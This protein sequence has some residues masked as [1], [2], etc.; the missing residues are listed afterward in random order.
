VR[1]RFQTR[2][3]RPICCGMD[4]FEAAKTHADAEA[5]APVDRPLAAALTALGFGLFV[6]GVFLAIR[7]IGAVEWVAWIAASLIYAGIAYGDSVLGWARHRR[8]YQ[9]KLAELRSERSTVSL[10]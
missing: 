3:V 1:A 5:P 6:I 7:W 8:E 10:H 2:R 4:I 9:Q